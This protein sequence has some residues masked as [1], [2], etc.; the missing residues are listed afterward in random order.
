[1]FPWAKFRRAKGAVKLHVGLDHA[2]HVP[3]FAYVS[4]GKTGDM[5]AA[6]SLRLPRGSIVAV[7][8]AYVDFDWINSLISQGV[9]LVIRLK[10]RIEFKVLERRPANRAQGV[11]SDQTIVFTS[12]PGRKRCPVPATPDR[13]PRPGNRPPLRLPDR[14]LPAFRE[15]RRAVYP[16]SK[17][18]S[19]ATRF[20]HLWSNPEKFAYLRR[21]GKVSAC[22]TTNCRVST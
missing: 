20:R 5:E 3:A 1:M 8:R 17:T 21:T 14:Q 11:T 12:A 19:G 22:R 9:S 15:D 10:R 13:L 4:D 2:G 18:V 16:S 7:D 6:R